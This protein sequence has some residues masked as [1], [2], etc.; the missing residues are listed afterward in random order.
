MQD[1]FY[2]PESS[3]LSLNRENGGNYYWGNISSLATSGSMGQIL[4]YSG[5]DIIAYFPVAATNVYYGTFPQ[6]FNVFTGSTESSTY[7]YINWRFETNFETSSNIALLFSGSMS[8]LFVS[9]S[10]NS[11][12]I[13]VLNDIPGY[14]GFLVST[15]N[16]GS[17][18]GV[19]ASIVITDITNATYLFSQSVIDTSIT[20]SQYLQSSSQYDVLYKLEFYT[21][22]P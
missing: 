10:N 22:A 19:T 21:L 5:S 14:H 7:S 20:T 2:I 18:S 6:T 17:Y 13:A 16:T 4:A 11:E 15:N 3:S 1:L 9:A 12:G 8:N